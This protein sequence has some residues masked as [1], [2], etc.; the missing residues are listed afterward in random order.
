MH[1]FLGFAYMFER[2]VIN[3]EPGA[4]DQREQLANRAS[5]Y[6]TAHATLKDGVDAVTTTYVQPRIDDPS[7][8][9]AQ[10]ETGFVFKVS[11]W[12]STSISFIAR[13]DSNPATRVLR[14]DTELNNA[15][16]VTR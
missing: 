7:D 9:R 15:I 2:D 14:T 8:L 16:T 5:M 4:P 11:T 10:S 12:L 13:Y 6:L 1:F 3:V